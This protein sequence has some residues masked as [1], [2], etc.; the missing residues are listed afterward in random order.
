MLGLYKTLCH[1]DHGNKNF[2]S[3]HSFQV[4][5]IVE[6]NHQKNG[7]NGQ[8]GQNDQNGQNGHA[9]AIEND[10]I[11]IDPNEIKKKREDNGSTSTTSN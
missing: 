3:I 5:T 11:E 10:L 6:V 9:E 7:Q 2:H 4:E 8:N 1:I